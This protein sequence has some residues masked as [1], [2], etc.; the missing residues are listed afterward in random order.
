MYNTRGTWTTF[1]EYCLK[2]CKV[3]LLFWGSLFIL[4]TWQTVG[5]PWP[6]HPIYSLTFHSI[7]IFL[8]QKVCLTMLKWQSLPPKT[9]WFHFSTLPLLVKVYSHRYI[10]L[11][12]LPLVNGSRQHLY[13]EGFHQAWCP[14]HTPDQVN[15]NHLEWSPEI[16]ILKASW[17]LQHVDKLTAT[18][19][20]R[21][22]Y[23]Q[24]KPRIYQRQY[25]LE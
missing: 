2:G 13:L 1:E 14:S 11:L 15:Q 22:K 9:P 21:H 23:Q 3:R 24:S 5:S 6:W 18:P 10:S 16:S 7:G 4:L 8:T 17:W 12:P 19:L 20:E 25:L